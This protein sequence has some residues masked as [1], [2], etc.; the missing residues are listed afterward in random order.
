MRGRLSDKLDVYS[1][2][3]VTLEILS[4]RK[5]WEYPSYDL[6]LIDYVSIRNPS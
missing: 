3:V 5:N 4:G 2:G 6:N 1:F